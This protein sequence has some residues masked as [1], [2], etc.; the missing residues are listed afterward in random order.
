MAQ[1][2]V[3]VPIYNVSAYL[4][5]SL[6]S[7]KNQSYKDFEILCVNDG[8]TD[9]SATVIQKF[10]DSDD[11]FKRL[12]KQNGGLSDARNF[13][14]KQVFTPYV[15]FLD[16]DDYYELDMLE[17]AMNRMTRDQLDCVVFDYNQFFDETKFKEH[18]HLPFESSKIYNPKT[19]KAIFAYVNNAAWNKLYRTDLFK[20]NN[21]EYP[22]G[23]RHQDL[24]TTFRYLTF[25]ERVGFINK[26]LY[27]YLADRPNNITQQV[28]A[29]IDHILDMVQLNISFFKERNI[30][31]M[32]YEELKY[33][34]VINLLYSFRKLPQFTNRRFVFDFIDRTFGLLKS[35]FP[36]YAKS[37]Y[38]IWDEPN[39][40]I[41]LNKNKLKA[42]YLYTSLRR[43]LC[44]KS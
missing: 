14:L 25:C 26:P 27:N 20:Q 4:E 29:K 33:L 30:F 17:L 43:H 34:S 16:S 3:V 36:D 32:Y 15:M 38:P 37:M 28:D 39:A 5:R 18:I 40:N 23:Y 22:F 11:R 1:V 31:E 8:S 2:T 6:G 9:D 7:L 12:D 44:K 19:D 41:Y 35:N 10:V 13:G 24:G 42:Y 21:I